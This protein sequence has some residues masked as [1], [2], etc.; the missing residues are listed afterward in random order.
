MGSVGLHTGAVGSYWGLAIVRTL[1][2]GV[3]CQGLG[4][5]LLR[6]CPQT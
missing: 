1:R 5:G 6:G 3:C 2:V 4:E